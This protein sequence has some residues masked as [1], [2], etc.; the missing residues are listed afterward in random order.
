MN[1]QPQIDSL[2]PMN[3]QTSAVASGAPAGHWKR[4]RILYAVIA[5]CVAPVV[6]SYLAF[7]M[8]PPSGRTNYGTLLTP[9]PAPPM[10]LKTL[11]GR[12]FTLDSLAGKWVLVVAAGGDCRES[13]ASALLQMRQQRLMT[14]KDRDRVE[15]LWLV[16]DEAPLSTVLMREYEGTHFVR[17]H[18]ADVR[19]FLATDDAA[20]EG[21]VWLIDPMGNL[22]LRWPQ[23]P[24]PQRVKKDLAR[25]LTASSHWIRIERKD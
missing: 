3:P 25:L 22:M 16:T 7:Y 19:A 13:C 4:Y 2:P 18:A 15:R 1:S 8:F 21:H 5:V 20:P 17:V 23:D 11:D 14:G 6:A 10:A 12:S 24:E 9:Q